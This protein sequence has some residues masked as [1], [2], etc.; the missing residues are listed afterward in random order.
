MDGA[1][2][3]EGVD[4]VETITIDLSGLESKWLH[5]DLLAPSA[6]DGAGQD[7][8]AGLDGDIVVINSTPYHTLSVCIP[9]PATITLLGLLVGLGFI[10]KGKRYGKCLSKM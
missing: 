9:E 7:L 5:F 6:S 2:F 4:L 1:E 3:P 10:V 8:I